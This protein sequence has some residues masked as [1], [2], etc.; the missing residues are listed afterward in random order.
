MAETAAQLVGRSAELEGMDRAL[1]VLRGGGFRA[2]ELVG[3]PGIGKTRLLEE[4][5]ERADARGHL[6]LAGSASE[7]EAT[8]P[9]WVFVDALD[10]YVQGLDRERLEALAP[11]DVAELTPVLP[12]LDSGRVGGTVEHGRYRLYGAV[13][14]LLEVLAARTP[15][16]LL[17]DDVHW[18]DAGSI[19]LLASLLRRPPRAAVLVAVAVRPG[20]MPERLLSTLERAH[21]GGDL[22]RVELHA[23]SA[24]EARELLGSEADAV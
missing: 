14:R 21:R 16:V 6:V 13:R 17:L 5:G 1:D 19:E 7:L 11:E 9:L 4:L 15:L 2:L 3:E 18:A 12:A 20:Q 22:R 8:L 23:L 24:R 10:E